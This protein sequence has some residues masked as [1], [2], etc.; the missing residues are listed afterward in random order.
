MSE[1]HL[2]EIFPKGWPKGCKMVI[3]DEHGRIL[4]TKE[5]EERTKANVKAWLEQLQGWGLNFR[6]FYIDRCKAYKQAIAEVSRDATIQYDYFLIIQNIFRHLWR[7]MVA[8]RKEIKAEAKQAFDEE[9]RAWLEGLAKRLW[10][11][12]GLLFNSLPAI[13]C[14]AGSQIRQGL[15]V[16]RGP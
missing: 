8:H 15:N 7:A 11:H 5:V 1:A 3:K 14:T 6:A 4:A 13:F 10:K 16:R 9:Y 2:D 12:R